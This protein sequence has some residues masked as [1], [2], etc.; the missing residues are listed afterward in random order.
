MPTFSLKSLFV[1]V[2]LAAIASHALARPTIIAALIVALVMVLSLSVLTVIG[3]WKRR[4]LLIAVA[5]VCYCYLGMADGGVLPGAERYLPSEWLLCR[6]STY[7]TVIFNGR[8]PSKSLVIWA[9]RDSLENKVKDQSS[10]SSSKRAPR[11]LLASVAHHAPDGDD[12]VSIPLP[13]F[14]LTKV[15]T[16][17]TI[18]KRDDPQNRAFFII[19]HCLF[20]NSVVII[21][22]MVQTQ[23]YRRKRVRDKSS[24]SHP[25][26]CPILT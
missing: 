12:T 10:V 6:C 21:V 23:L 5:L 19:G 14:A 20:V 11:Q 24:E 1:L 17:I 2:T 16:T 15:G 4:P 26:R 7:H 13:R 3:F 9:V 18:F 22:G 25:C 8:K